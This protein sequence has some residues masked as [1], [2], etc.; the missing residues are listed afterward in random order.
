MTME[1]RGVINE[2]TPGQCCGKPESCGSEK[3]AA[4][5][6]KQYTLPFPGLEPTTEKQADDMQESA[7]NDA[8]DAVEEETDASTE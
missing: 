5:S 3:E 7:V 8:I 1:K 4:S 6:Q 2:N